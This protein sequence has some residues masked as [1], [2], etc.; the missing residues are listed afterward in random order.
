MVRTG[1]LDSI[2][3]S[4]GGVPKRPVPEAAVGVEGLA[5]DRQRDLRHHGG[6]LRAVC[7][8]SAEVIA[9][10]RSEGHPIA[11]GSTGENLTLSG[12]PWSEVVPGAELTVGEVR[13]R[14]E[15]YAAPCETIAGSFADRRSARI[16]QKAHPGWSRVYAS[17]AAPG[18][19][20]AGDAVLLRPPAGH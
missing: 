1:R 13:L 14:V 17:V 2:Q 18:R 3:L 5:G 4:D 6:P 15:S 19:V 16:S 8:F 11:A 7:L 20:R 10:L 9:A 12:L